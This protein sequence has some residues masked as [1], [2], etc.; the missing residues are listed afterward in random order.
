M[1]KYTKIVILFFVFSLVGI[2]CATAQTIDVNGFEKGLSTDVQLLD[3]R[4]MEEFKE[5][6][7]KGA[8]LADWKEKEEFARRVASLDK[9]K[10]VFVYCLSGGR[11]AAALAYLEENGFTVTELEVLMNFGA[12]WCPPCRKMEPVLAELK[13]ENPNVG[14]LNI[15]AGKEQ[16]LMKA[17]SVKQIPTYI[18]YKNGEEVW[19]TSG[20]T[21]KSV[22]LSKLN[23]HQ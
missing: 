10:P 4:T 21:K 18:L 16:E 12:S 3:V 15:D 19:R 14:I 2:F 23:T 20:E 1:I 17:Y 11:S 7:L 6:H 9:K 8:M 13:T 5:G 22:I